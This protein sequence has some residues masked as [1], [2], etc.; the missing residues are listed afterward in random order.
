MPTTP[1]TLEKIRSR[2]LQKRTAIEAEER[3][4]QERVT[5]ARIAPAGPDRDYDLAEA[6]KD[7]AVNFARRNYIAEFL[8]DLDDLEP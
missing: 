7:L 3:L 6:R 2:W 5:A 4:L 8:H 1:P